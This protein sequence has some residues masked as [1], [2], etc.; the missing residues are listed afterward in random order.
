MVTSVGA[1]SPRRALLVGAS[2]S[3]VCSLPV[4]FTGA[5]AVQLTNDLAFGA[6]GIGGAVAMF[7]GTMALTSIHLGRLVDRL[8]ATVSLRIAA[9]IV[10]TS[11]LGIATLASSWA[12]LAA[13]LV[14]AGLAAALAQPAANRLLVNRVRLARLGTA[15]GLKQSAPPTASMLAGL[16]VPAIALTVGWRWAYG[17]VTVLALAAAVAVGPRPTSGATPRATRRS[18]AQTALRNRPTLA[19]LAGGFGL[20]F[21]ASSGVLAFY[22]E[23]AVRAGTSQQVAGLVFAAGSLAA[24]ATRLVAGIASDRRSFSPLR[25][26]AGL[27][28]TGALGLALLATGRPTTMGFGALVA[29]AGTWGF[30]GLFWF[31]LV[32]AYP[33]TPGRITGAMAPA[34]IGGIVGPLGF[35]AV[36]ANVSYAVAWS[37]TAVV[38]L[39]AAGA[40]RF[41]AHRLRIEA[42]AQDGQP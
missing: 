31:A 11:A 15:F 19:V 38:A 9:G 8:G 39:L 27:L 17:L 13:G 35:G 21:I 16:S 32:S 36:A 25:L 29:L 24:V 14:V 37:G 18:G 22:V 5:M 40:L 2:V 20:A 12:T 4:F 42:A 7:F 1:G 3:V 26:S 10:A 33:D 34:A 41:G 30:P 23:A 6:V 28:V